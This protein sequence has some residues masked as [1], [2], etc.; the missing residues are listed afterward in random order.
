MFAYSREEL[1]KFLTED[2]SNIDG[3]QS[4]ETFIYLGAINKWIEMP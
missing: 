3:I 1:N 4:T 2:L